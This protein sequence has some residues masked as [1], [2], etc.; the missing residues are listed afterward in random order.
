MCVRC[1]V[2]EVCGVCGVCMRCVVWGGQCAWIGV[3]VCCLYPMNQN[4][5]WRCLYGTYVCTCMKGNV[6]ILWVLGVRGVSVDVV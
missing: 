5:V 1:V 2:C 6:D 4:H 3:I